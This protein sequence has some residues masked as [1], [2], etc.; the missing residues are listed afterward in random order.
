LG[1]SS[2]RKRVRQLGGRVEWLEIDPRGIC[3]RVE[4]PLQPRPQPPA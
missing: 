2:V 1:L 3:C 4:V